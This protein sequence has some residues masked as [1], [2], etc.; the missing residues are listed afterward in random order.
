MAGRGLRLA[1]G[2]TDCLLLDYGGNVNRHGPIDRIR[3]PRPAK[4]TGK[5]RFQDVSGSSG[6]NW[7]HDSTAF[8]QVR[9][10]PVWKVAYDVRITK[11]GWRALVVSHF[12]SDTRLVNQ[13]LM[14]EHPKA[15]FNAIK[16]W[17]EIA[18]RPP[19]STQDA[20]EMA[21]CGQLNE[22]AY[23]LCEKNEQGFDNIVAKEFE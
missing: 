20:Y 12:V 7:N 14:F 1:P 9:R 4:K 5:K 21:L 17:H 16:A 11:S 6:R 18:D 15:R 10:M 19:T 8:S 13:W 2:K 3:P 23:I 22:P